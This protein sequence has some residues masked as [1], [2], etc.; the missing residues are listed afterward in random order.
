[1]A[2]LKK[3][4]PFILLPLLTGCYEDFTPGIDTK[5]VLC[6]NSL[7]TAGEP[8]E[9]TVTHTWL[10]T[11]EKASFDHKVDDAE[12]YIYANGELVDDGFLP[13]EGDRIKIVAQSKTYGSAEAEV[14][15]PKSV[16]IVEVKWEA[17]VTDIW[18]LDNIIWTDG[19]E[20][21][22]EDED[23]D[24]SDY[25]LKLLTV[26]LDLRARVV[27]KDPA[28]AVNYYQFSY[29][30]F[31]VEEDSDYEVTTLHPLTFYEGTF[32]DW[33]EPIFSEHLGTFDI[34]TGSGS[35]GFTFFSDRQFSGK[36]YKL[37]IL[38]DG[39]RCSIHSE[40][41]SDVPCD[42]GYILTLATVSPSYYNWASYRW[43]TEEGTLNDLS[44]V[45]LSDPIWGYSNVSTGAGV[46]A[47]RSLSSRTISLRSFLQ[48]ELDKLS[49]GN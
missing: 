23:S 11:D 38:F 4:Y 3:L 13:S 48:N 1:M 29:S 14:T 27:I 49:K 2:I 21:D 22:D 8:I 37:R 7:I 32:Q 39:A 18:R 44:D 15:V 41:L 26:D 16:P 30:S 36:D 35:Y 25:S 31:P 45:G 5:P 34:M 10:Y 12:V 28:D 40:D 19:N 9:V 20:S 6:L 33:E 24:N 17:T 46:V 43:N 42:F 47:A